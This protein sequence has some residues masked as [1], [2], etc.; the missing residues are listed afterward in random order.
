MP[1]S[2]SKLAGASEYLNLV[3]VSLSICACWVVVVL[4]EVQ[5]KWVGNRQ[6]F[7]TSADNSNTAARR[8]RRFSEIGIRNDMGQAIALDCRA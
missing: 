1:N 5:A 6:P 4:F 2:C 8:E 3:A 7:P